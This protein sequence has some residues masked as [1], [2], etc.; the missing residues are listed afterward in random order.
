MAQVQYL[1]TFKTL[2]NYEQLLSPFELCLVFERGQY[3]KAGIN[4]I[5]NV[6]KCCEVIIKESNKFSYETLNKAIKMKCI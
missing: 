3:L 5:R 1:K 6:V 2:M 4:G